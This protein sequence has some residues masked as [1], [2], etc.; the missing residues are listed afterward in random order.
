VDDARS[1]VSNQELGRKLAQIG[2][3]GAAV[4]RTLDVLLRPKGARHSEPT[5]S[6]RQRPDTRRV[7]TGHRSLIEKR[8]V[9][10]VRV[11]RGRLPCIVAR[12]YCPGA[13]QTKGAG[14]K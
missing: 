3:Y 2:S 13:G 5:A 12:W 11:S 7:A 14:T 10:C 9:N 1:R 8:R 4:R 6:R